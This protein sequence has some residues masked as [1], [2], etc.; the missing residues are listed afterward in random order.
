MS[1]AESATNDV[2]RIHSRERRYAMGD[3]YALRRYFLAFA[4]AARTRQV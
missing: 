2:R 3:S 4:V 1:L